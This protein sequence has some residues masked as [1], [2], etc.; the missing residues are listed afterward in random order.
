MTLLDTSGNQPKEAF[1]GGAAGGGKSE[2][3][4][5][6]AAQYVELP[7]YS[8]LILRKTLPDLAQAGALIPRSQEWWMGTAAKWHENK[9][10]WTFPSGAIIRFGYL[11]RDSDI[12]NYFGSEYHF[13]GFDECTQFPFHHYRNLLSR[14]RRKAVHTHIPLRY[15]AGSNPGGI[16]HD[17]VK[18]RFLSAE[19][20]KAG[21]VFVPANLKDNPSLNYAEYR[22]T[23]MELDPIMRARLLEGDWSV[24]GSA[25]NFDRE[26]FGSPIELEDLPPLNS[27]RAICRYWD[28]AAT[29]P[30]P[31][32]EDEA[33]YTVGTLLG[34]HSSGEVYV[35]HVSRFQGNPSKVETLVLQQAMIDRNEIN[36]FMEQEPG[37]SGKVMIDHYEKLLRGYYF[38]GI[39][40]TGPK[41][42]R[43]AR[44]SA[45]A[46]NHK[47]KIVRGDWNAKWLDELEGF[48]QGKHDDQVDSVAGA[49]NQVTLGGEIRESSDRIKDMFN[50]RARI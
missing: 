20:M 46:A 6:A 29:A 50:W 44:F 38:K 47:V 42:A 41:T 1:Y 18:E 12:N 31:G 49:Y 13:I 39:R 16:G 14:L 3:L 27:F 36:I 23:L 40:S 48:P 17:W 4:L 35:I 34:L 2:A 8:A 19:G 21:R 9:K 25:G 33:D 15:R 32:R 43:A 5:M 26:W 24:S 10:R 45:A 37:A 28:T 30:L 22:A 11:E 7:G